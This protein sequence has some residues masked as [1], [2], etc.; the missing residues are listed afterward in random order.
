MQVRPYSSGEPFI[1]A[2]EKSQDEGNFEHVERNLPKLRELI[3]QM[4]DEAYRLAQI[5]HRAR[6]VLLRNG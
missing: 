2:L 6:S 5:Q 4:L 1:E 3:E